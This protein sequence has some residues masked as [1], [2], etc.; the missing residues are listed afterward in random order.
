MFLKLEIK[1]KKNYKTNLNWI[2]KK[3]PKFEPQGGVTQF[4]TKFT[5]VSRQYRA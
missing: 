1:D 5:P 2:F 4:A 3:N